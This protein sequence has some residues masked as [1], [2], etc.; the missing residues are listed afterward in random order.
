MKVTQDKP[1]AYVQPPASAERRVEH[2]D[3]FEPL[4]GPD[5]DIQT[6]RAVS[7]LAITVS[8]DDNRLPIVSQ[9]G[10]MESVAA[11]ERQFVDRIA[12]RVL[13][14]AALMAAAIPPQTSALI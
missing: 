8:A 10:R 7:S 2:I 13:N 6:G 1:V 9:T 3:E 12:V 5:R 11:G 4:A 14:V